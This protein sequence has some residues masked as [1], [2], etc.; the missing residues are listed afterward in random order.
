MHNNLQN[1]FTECSSELT[2][3]THRKGETKSDKK[4]LYSS[5]EEYVHCYSSKGDAK[6]QKNDN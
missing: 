2:C 3:V 6:V 5:P 4:I 1:D